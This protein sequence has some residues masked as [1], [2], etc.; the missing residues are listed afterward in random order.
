ML[1]N[2]SD[3]RDLSQE[4]KCNPTRGFLVTA[5]MPTALERQKYEYLRSF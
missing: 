4:T 5:S 1:L 3:I 2:I